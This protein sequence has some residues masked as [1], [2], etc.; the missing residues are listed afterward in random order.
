MSVNAND[1]IPSGT[2][3]KNIFFLKLIELSQIRW[4]YGSSRYSL[5]QGYRGRQEAPIRQRTGI[6]QR[7]RISFLLTVDNGNTCI[8]Q[9]RRYLEQSRSLYEAWGAHRKVDDI[10]F[11]LLSTIEQTKNCTLRENLVPVERHTY[12]L[13]YPHA[14]DWK[15]LD[16]PG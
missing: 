10:D 6:G 4:R 2:L 9:R 3:N 1:F 7:A 11:L 8:G 5:R 14:E 12:I 16:L 13:Q 15:Y